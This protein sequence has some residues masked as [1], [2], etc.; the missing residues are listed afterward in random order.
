MRKN[1]P[2]SAAAAGEP[3]DPTP[4][5]GRRAI[6]LKTM[7]DVRVEMARVYSDARRK[8]I[9]PEAG[10]KLI[11]MLGQVGRVIEGSDLERR[12]DELAKRMGASS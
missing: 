8:T 10:S 1:Q 2:G 3:G 6:R 7:N 9:E 12:I 11:Y 4:G 5:A